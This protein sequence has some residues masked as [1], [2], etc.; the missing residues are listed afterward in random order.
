MIKRTHIG[1]L[2][3]GLY[4]T[5]PI[6]ARGQ[7]SICNEIQSY[8]P[9]DIQSL[10]LRDSL[11]EIGIDTII[12]YRHWLEKN[13]YNGYGKVMWF[14]RGQYFQ[15]KIE[16]E[17]N[18][19]DSETKQVEFSKLTTG[20]PFKFFYSNQIDTTTTNPTKQGIQMSHDAEHLVEVWHRDQ[21]FCFS[22]SGLLVLFNTDN[23]RV[24]FVKL[25]SDKN[26]S[27]V[28]IKGK[29]QGIH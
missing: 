24:Q 9:I 19:C 27:M 21:R 14:E 22:I 18:C 17:N 7:V 29:R 6:Q 11:Q 16:F 10:H 12:V 25:L 23:P 4:L 1:L 15:Y 5:S 20:T 8:H 28:I 2:V 13:G 26:D 3:L